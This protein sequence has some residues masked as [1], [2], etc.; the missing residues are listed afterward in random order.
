MTLPHFGAANGR[1]YWPAWRKVHLSSAARLGHLN[2]YLTPDKFVTSTL[3]SFLP[4]H[5][6]S[7]TRRFC[8]AFKTVVG[9]ASHTCNELL[10]REANLEA[11]ETLWRLEAERVAA[12][13]RI[14]AE[15]T[16]AHVPDPDPT[17]KDGAGGAH[18]MRRRRFSDVRQRRS[19]VAEEM[20][21]KL[22]EE[23]GKFEGRASAATEAIEA[24]LAA[25][26]RKSTAWKHSSAMEECDISAANH[27][28]L[29]LASHLT[30]MEEEK[31]MRSGGG[32][33]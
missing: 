6:D 28:N 33:K 19:S 3:F 9:R 8:A 24:E 18:D 17:L 5:E 25:A 20:Q 13:A 15:V 31:K 12:N 30:D 32:V 27:L 23:R 7:F 22:T 26:H 14:R 11:K 1:S 16:A 21:L 2:I 10:K 4:E 29:N